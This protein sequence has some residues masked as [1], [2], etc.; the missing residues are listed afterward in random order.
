L[1]QGGRHADH[2]RGAIIKPADRVQIVFQPISGHR[3]DDHPR[4]IR[5]Q[6]LADIGCGT[7]RIAHV[8]QTVEK[9]NKVEV[10]SG[11]LFGG[12]HFEPSI[13]RDPVFAGMR[14]GVLDRARVEVVADEFGV[15]ECFCHQHGRPAMTASDIGN[16]CPAL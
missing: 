16:F 11:I 10:A 13:A 1:R 5:F 9:R 2:R 6:R 15:R 14:L 3:L 8:M 12:R 7:G 4:T